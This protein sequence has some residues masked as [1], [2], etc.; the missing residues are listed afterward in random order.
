VHHKLTRI[1]TF[2]QRR[3]PR[4]HTVLQEQLQVAD[5]AVQAVATANIAGDTDTE[6]VG[7]ITWMNPIQFANHELCG[8]CPPL[9]ADIDTHSI[10]ASLPTPVP[11]LEAGAGWYK[12]YLGAIQ[13]RYDLHDGRLAAQGVSLP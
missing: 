11:S 10:L 2:T 6:E 12:D 4:D 1:S 7:V 13:R 8:R 9:L 3:R 5:N